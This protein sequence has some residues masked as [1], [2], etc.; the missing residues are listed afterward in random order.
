MNNELEIIHDSRNIR[1]RQSKKY[2]NKKE[3]SLK[4]EL[5]LKRQLSKEKNKY[6]SFEKNEN[7]KIIEKE[8]SLLREKSWYRIRHH[9][10]C[11]YCNGPKHL[12][13]KRTKINE[14]KIFDLD[15]SVYDY[16]WDKYNKNKY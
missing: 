10:H 3:K 14:K 2:P 4:L 15:F 11:L 8:L 5:S 1:K 7:I 6:N 9:N 12:F 16:H 13:K